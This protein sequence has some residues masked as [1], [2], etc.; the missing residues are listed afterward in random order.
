MNPLNSDVAELLQQINQAL[1]AAHGDAVKAVLIDDRLTLVAER[2]NILN[3]MG[4]NAVA[5][6]ELGMLAQS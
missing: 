1:E 4:S 2:G 5:N 6:A 3:I